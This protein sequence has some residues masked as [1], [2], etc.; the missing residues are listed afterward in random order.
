[1][2]SLLKEDRMRSLRAWLGE[3]AADFDALL[4]PTECAACGIESGSAVFCGE[5]EEKLLAGA[6]DACER[7]ASRLGPWSRSD[8]GLC[9][10]CR[11]RRLGFDAAFALG[12]YS[13]PLR[14]LC[15]RVKHPTDGWLARRLIDLLM[16]ARRGAIE[17][18]IGVRPH[19]LG[20]FAP[21]VVPV[22]L[23][24]LR[25]WTRG[26]NQAEAYARRLAAVLG[27]RYENA[28]RRV[29]ATPKLAGLSRTERAEVMREAF[30][31]R[32]GYDKHV[33]GR[34]IALVDDV[35]T[36]GA[37]CD[38][39]ARTLKQAGATRVVVVV[40]GRTDI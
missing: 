37:T 33:R 2:I 32:P 8:D 29:V 26:Y 40:I 17:R 21:L 6:G 4:F 38:S 31:V 1:M 10:W 28:L 13:E 15:L 18:A 12:P 20:G 11:G 19:Y 25:N 22:P 5:C 23:H 14:T 35:M 34:V 16:K 36:S 3:F 27:I 9:R 24:R 39:A 30:G 7:C